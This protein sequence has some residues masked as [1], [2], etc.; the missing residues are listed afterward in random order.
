MNPD[1]NLAR[2]FG[3]ASA[4]TMLAFVGNIVVGKVSLVTGRD[5]ASPLDG[6]P[7]FLLLLLAVALFVTRA[8]LLSRERERT[9]A[10][11]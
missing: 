9:D 7:E 5:L 10:S 8:M 11:P 3:I 6:A 4:V 2:R 1:G